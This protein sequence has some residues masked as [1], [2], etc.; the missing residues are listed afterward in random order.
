MVPAKTPAPKIQVGLH[1]D[2]PYEREY[3]TP[4]GY[5]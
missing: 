1:F 2:E 5:K 3:K 4:N